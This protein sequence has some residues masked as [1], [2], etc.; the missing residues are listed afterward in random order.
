MQ[1]DV[2]FLFDRVYFRRD[3][4][5]EIFLDSLGTDETDEERHNVV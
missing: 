3:L 2:M 4:A 5:R 1:I